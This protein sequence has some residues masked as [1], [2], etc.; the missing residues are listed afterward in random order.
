MLGHLED[1]EGTP[2]M[3][4][5][6]GNPHTVEHFA[7]PT[8]TGYRVYAQ[9]LFGSETIGFTNSIPAAE[10][11]AKADFLLHVNIIRAHQGDEMADELLKEAQEGV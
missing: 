8:I 2:L 6:R 9:D 11:M 3:I 4:K 10:A 7:E 5:L 1:L